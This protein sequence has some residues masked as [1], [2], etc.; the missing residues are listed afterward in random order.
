MPRKKP[1]SLHDFQAATP[2]PTQEQIAYTYIRQ[3]ITM[4][5]PNYDLN[6][7]SHLAENILKAAKYDRD[8]ANQYV[9]SFFSKNTHLI[10][11]KQFV[12]SVLGIVILETFGGLRSSMSCMDEPSH[13]NDH[14]SISRLTSSIERLTDLIENSSTKRIAYPNY[15]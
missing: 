6:A 3:M 2:D 13:F 7:M 4:H 8:L 11:K 10:T 5:T 15:M 14:P 12:K 1:V 9:D